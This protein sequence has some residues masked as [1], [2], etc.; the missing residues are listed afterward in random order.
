MS[1]RAA[2]ARVRSMLKRDPHAR[3]EVWRQDGAGAD[4]FT[5]SQHPDLTLTLAELRE[6]PPDPSARRITVLRGDA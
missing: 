1:T 4:V 5:S 2:L 6:S 3:W